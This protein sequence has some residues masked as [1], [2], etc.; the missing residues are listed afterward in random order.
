LG[1]QLIDEVSRN[2]TTALA[3][4]SSTATL[5][6]LLRTFVHTVSAQSVVAWNTGIAIVDLREVA[7]R[8]SVVRAGVAK[9]IGVGVQTVGVET[10]QA[11]S[12]VTAGGARVEANLAQ[13][14]TSVSDKIAH[15]GTAVVGSGTLKAVGDITK[16]T[17]SID[18]TVSDLTGHANIAGLT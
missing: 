2:A 7:V 3:G 14:T 13:A 4:V 16:N 9:A 18:K 6:L 8:A 11:D 15:A 5:A 1:S 10:G 12:I 17:A